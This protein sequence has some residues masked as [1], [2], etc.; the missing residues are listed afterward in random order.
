MSCLGIYFKEKCTIKPDIYPV[1]APNK[2]KYDKYLNNEKSLTSIEATSICVILCNIAETPE[3]VTNDVTRKLT[4]IKLRQYD[5]K[6]AGNAYIIIVGRPTKTAGRTAFNET[7]KSA[8]HLPTNN[9][10]SKITILPS[11]NL[12]YGNI[13]KIGGK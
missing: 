11:P 9:M 1:I 10:E 6:L 7:I 12:K 3:I 13:G 2:I 8:G 5:T 4:N